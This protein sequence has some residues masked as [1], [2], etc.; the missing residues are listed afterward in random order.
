MM[1]MSW[2][3]SQFNTWKLVSVALLWWGVSLPAVQAQQ[4]APVV[5]TKQGKVQG[6]QEGRLRVFRGI[7][8]AQ[9][10]V[11]PLRFRP[12][13]PIKR[14]GSTISA[15]Q[16][17][18]RA[19][20]T[21]GPTGVQ[22]SEDCLYLNVWAP[23]VAKRRPVVVW[24]HGGA[25][26]GGAGQD[27]DSW[28]FADQDTVVAV[29]INY[30]LGSLGF[31]HLGNQL[32]PDY[33]QAGNCGLLDAVAALRWVH[34]NI[35]AFGGDPKRVTIMG[36]SAGAKLVGGLLVTP[37]AQGLFQQAILESG[38]VQAVRDTATAASV[39]RQLL[40]ELKTTDARALLRLPADSLVRA[41]GRFANGSGG[42]QVFGPVLDGRTITAPPA[43]YLR[44]ARPV[45][46]LLGSNLIEARLFSGPGSVLHQPSEEALRLTFGPAN[47]PF[48]WRAYQKQRRQ[49]P[50]EAAW[51]TVLT[52]YLYRLSTYR[53]ANQLAAQGTPTWLYRFDYTDA[54]TQPTHAQELAFV[55]NAPEGSSS[56][57][58]AAATPGAPSKASNPALATAM[59]AHW[60]RFIK[61]GQPG[62][63]WPRYT[64]ERRE[65]MIFKANSQ[66]EP[67]LAPYEDPAFP[68]QGYRR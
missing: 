29:S 37:A 60:A 8:Y 12:P 53:L 18:S 25:F 58:T 45:R 14:Y 66:P 63:N 55:W 9:P 4:V 6:V 65:V 51:N 39:T 27:N 40:Q 21:G 30:R 41:Q 3:N 42:L 44:Q 56:A 49:E 22:G 16:F 15:T 19:T 34:Q 36:E 68:V 24:M 10:P 11:G 26:T 62:P 47:S 59:H 7:P 23:A 35:A 31:L 17:S 5:K 33:A 28:T 20:Q 1:H 67:V 32:G 64:P 2:L 38:A 48:V 43:E 57:A 54:R 13:Q 52:D 50:D 61:T 46:V